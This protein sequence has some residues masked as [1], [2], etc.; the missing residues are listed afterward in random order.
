MTAGKWGWIKKYYA[1]IS[2]SVV[3]RKRL[4]WSDKNWVNA[5]KKQYLRGQACGLSAVVI[6][7][8]CIGK[9]IFLALNGLFRVGN[10]DVQAT[11]QLQK[12]QQTTS[13]ETTSNLDF[14]PHQS[15]PKT[16]P[17]MSSYICLF[18]IRFVCGW[19]ANFLV[20]WPFQII[21]LFL[22]SHPEA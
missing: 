16:P 20:N 19:P 22:L 8:T 21:H 11:L 10:L 14:K 3:L 12:A 13:I 17:W 4:W 18:A 9:G 2:F 5:G 15:A 7:R 1:E 6:S